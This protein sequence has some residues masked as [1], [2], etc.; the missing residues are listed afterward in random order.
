MRTPLSVSFLLLVAACGDDGSP[1]MIVDAMPDAPPPIDAPTCSAPMKM[2]GNS[3]LD[4]S[5]DE[6]NCGDCGVECGG[7]EAC[8]ASACACPTPFV[9][10]T[11]EAGQFDQ[12]FDAGGGLTI[13]FNPNIDGSINP[14]VV[15]F[16]AQT[17]ID[18]DIDLSTVT[19]GDAPLVGAG[20]NF[21]LNTMAIDASYIV[22]Q[23]TLHLDQACATHVEGT[24]TNATF[25][26]ITGGF[27]NPAIDP[28]GCTFTVATVTFAMGTTPCPPP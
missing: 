4:V 21:D 17:P 12:L 14:F 27:E 28:D 22:T 5:S 16:D 7:G 10:A 11:L 15:G 3:C 18:A 26:G 19:V 6:E 2:C 13:A 8:T 20:Y 9:P 24:L 25:Q 1:I 23:G